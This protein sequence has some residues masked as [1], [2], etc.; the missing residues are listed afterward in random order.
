MFVIPAIDIIGGKVV[1]LTQGDYDR[2]KV[3]ADDPTSVAMSFKDAGAGLIHVVDLDGA[4]SG[5]PCNLDV[6]RAIA[7]KG[8]SIEL[9]GGI[10]NMDTLKMALD[11]GAARVVL[12]TSVVEDR[13]FAGNCLKEFGERI[14][15]GIDVKNG[16]IATRGWAEESQTG[17]DEVLKYFEAL[18]LKRI[19]YTDITKDGMMKG[20]NIKAV[21]EVLDSTKIKVI[22]SGGVSTLDDIKKLAALR[23]KGLEGAIV[24]KALYEG[25]IKIED[26]INVG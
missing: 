7:S 19:I 8:V 4:K 18:G 9:G 21:T 24:G 1:R 16:K 2:V 22:A 3:Y 26:I 5:R 15:F 25:T 10:R 14:V 17:L 13:A 6:V 12:G 20:P 23:E 11:S